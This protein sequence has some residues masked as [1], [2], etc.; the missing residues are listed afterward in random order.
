MIYKNII[1]DFDGVLFDTNKIKSSAI[2]EATLEII[3]NTVKT[4]MFV[5]YFV[6]NNGLPRE[7]KLR[8]FFQDKKI[9]TAI[10]KLYENLLTQRLFASNPTLGCKEFLEKLRSLKKNLFIISGGSKIEIMHLLKLHKLDVYFELVLTGPASKIE[11]AKSLTINNPTLFIGD[12]F[13]DLK[14]ADEMGWN[15][16]FLTDYSE[17]KIHEQENILN[18]SRNLKELYEKIKNWN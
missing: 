14:V 10:Q 1:F 18:K 15:F 7:Q 2:Y 3:Q 17:V 13:I 11:N 9:E 8:N 12:S 6:Q 16:V 4:E 5:E